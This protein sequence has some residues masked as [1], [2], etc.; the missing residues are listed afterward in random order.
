MSTD[1]IEH[2]RGWTHVDCAVIQVPPTVYMLALIVAVVNA[3]HLP[4]FAFT[5][6][7]R[8]FLVT[9]NVTVLSLP[10]FGNQDAG[11]TQGNELLSQFL[12]VFD[13]TSHFFRCDADF[14]WDS[15]TVESVVP[16]V[17]GKLC[18]VSRCCQ[19]DD[20]SNTTGHQYSVHHT[21]NCL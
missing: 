9:D 3:G 13:S 2:G 14:G 18:A 12:L 10:T 15:V 21:T 11:Y 4:Q 8:S 17:F 16:A 5:A 1:L 20:D 6:T 7:E 19:F